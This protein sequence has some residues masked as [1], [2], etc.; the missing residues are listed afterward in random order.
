MALWLW[1]SGAAVLTCR[2]EGRELAL[3]PLLSRA[4]TLTCGLEVKDSV[5]RCYVLGATALGLGCDI[6]GVFEEVTT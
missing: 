1:V 3:W 6:C 4:A 5:P 2:F